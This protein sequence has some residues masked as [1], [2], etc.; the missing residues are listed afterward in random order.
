MRKIDY[1]N[2]KIKK[3]LKN[4]EAYAVT[5]EDEEIIVHNA[6]Q[7][8]LKRWAKEFAKSPFSLQY[9]DNNLILFNAKA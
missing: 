9:E 2:T 6:D 8:M 7:T 3:F 1:S 5:Q 4:M